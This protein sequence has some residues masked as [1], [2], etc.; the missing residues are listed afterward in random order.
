MSAAYESESSGS[1][2]GTPAAHPERRV[3][4]AR[5]RLRLTPL[6][7][8]RQALARRHLHQHA[9]EPARPGRRHVSRMFSAASAAAAAAAVS[10]TLVCGLGSGM[11]VRLAAVA[12]PDSG[13]T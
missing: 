8:R 10:P 4:P 3:D 12:K 9:G 6:L 2:S 5:V 13:Q 1:L 11:P 7:R